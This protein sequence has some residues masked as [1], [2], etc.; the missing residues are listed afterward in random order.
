MEYIYKIKLEVRAYECDIEGIVNNSIYLSYLEHA[1]EKFLKSLGYN[2]FELTKKD[3]YLVVTRAEIEYKK[4]LSSGDEFFVGLNI[5]RL[6]SI[7]MEFL[8]DI[9][10]ENT[11]FTS[12]KIVVAVVDQK[13]KPIKNKTFLNELFFSIEKQKLP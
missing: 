6:S 2:F 1:R 13:A 3:I 10:I 7:R 9:F 5:K 8:Q 11:I 4:S 12:A